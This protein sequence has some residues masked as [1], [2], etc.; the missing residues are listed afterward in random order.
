ME[1]PDVDLPRRGP[2]RPRNPPKP[3]KTIL[4]TDKKPREPETAAVRRPGRPFKYPRGRPGRPKKVKDASG[5]LPF[6]LDLELD[7]VVPDLA[8]SLDADLV[9]PDSPVLGA[10]LMD[11]DLELDEVVPDLGGSMDTDLVAP[12]V[13]STVR[14]IDGWNRMFPPQ[15]LL[16]ALFALRGPSQPAE[17]RIGG[18]DFV[19]ST[20]GDAATLDGEPVSVLTSYIPDGST[21]WF[22]V[23][24]E[25]GDVFTT[26]TFTVS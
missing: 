23:E 10:V 12:E 9:A 24:T 15:G 4:V 7:E 20:T 14:D 17:G 2:G 6:D 1:P 25:E 13:T 18:L 5:M 22:N 26:P 16:D 8:S 19:Q 21:I 3:E 11:V